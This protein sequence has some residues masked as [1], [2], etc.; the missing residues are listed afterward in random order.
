VPAKKLQAR[1]TQRCV[2]LAGRLGV[3]S[4]LR[5]GSMQLK[6]SSFDILNDLNMN[7]KEYEYE[8][9]AAKCGKTKMCC[10]NAE[11]TNYNPYPKV[12]AVSV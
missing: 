11:Q 3:D 4:G 2:A 1:Q 6:P 5:F 7:Y 9:I 8:H 10:G 12:H